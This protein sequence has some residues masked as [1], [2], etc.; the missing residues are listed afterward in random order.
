VSRLQQPVAVQLASGPVHLAFPVTDARLVSVCG[1]RFG[2]ASVVPT[3][4]W[5]D[6]RARVC[7]ECEDAA[8]RARSVRQL[9]LIAGV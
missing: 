2:H 3:A 8:T 7:E 6:D 5:L 1:G 4:A 9:R